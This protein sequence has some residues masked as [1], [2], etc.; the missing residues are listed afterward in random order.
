LQFLAAE[1]WLAP[2]TRKQ[3]GAGAA[4]G[5]VIDA[6]EAIGVRAVEWLVIAVVP[7]DGAIDTSYFPLTGCHC[8]LDLNPIATRL[9]DEWRPSW[10]VICIKKVCRRMIL[11]CRCLPHSRRHTPSPTGSSRRFEY[12]ILNDER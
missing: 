7:T 8:S 3:D 12:Q 10:H 2:L 4:A 1:Y 5:Q 6:A 11:I 9:E